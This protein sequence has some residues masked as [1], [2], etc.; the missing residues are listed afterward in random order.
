[1]AENDEFYQMTMV[2]AFKELLRAL[3]QSLHVNVREESLDTY[4]VL[5]F[6]EKLAKKDLIVGLNNLLSDVESEYQRT[7]KRPSKYPSETEI[8]KHSRA[9]S[10]ARLASEKEL[11]DAKEKD[12][13]LADREFSYR[14]LDR[15]IER[16]G[17]ALTLKYF[18]EWRVIFVGDGIFGAN[19]VNPDQLRGAIGII[20]AMKD[21][22]DGKGDFGV[23]LQIARTRSNNQEKS[24]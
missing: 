2:A 17:F 24:A 20:P 11:A 16:F 22:A 10:R 14:V 6:R 7:G 12:Q 9:A 4:S 1:M 19:F 3:A 5:L 18:L 23:A 15:A 13:A 8:L 21:L